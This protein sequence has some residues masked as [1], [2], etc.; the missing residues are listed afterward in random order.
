GERFGGGKVDVTVRATAGALAADDVEIGLA[1]AARYLS[2][3][4]LLQEQHGVGGALDVASL[5]ALPGV[6]RVVEREL[7]EE[8]VRAPLVDA[9]GAALDALVAMREAEGAALE[10]ELRGRLARLEELVGASEGR[11]DEV[12]RAVRDRLRQRAEQPREETGL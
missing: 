3:A 1:T 5:L 10:R 8:R 7:G 12:Q 11:A 6:A 4:R 2:A 9:V